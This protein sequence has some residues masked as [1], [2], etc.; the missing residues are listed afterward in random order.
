MRDLHQSLQSQVD[1][2][3][4]LH[5]GY[6]CLIATPIEG[7]HEELGEELMGRNSRA[8]MAK[9]LSLSRLIAARSRS[10]GD[11][12]GTHPDSAQKNAV[13]T[14]REQGVSLRQT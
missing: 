12:L 9:S 14:C 11:F 6:Q 13:E 8:V 3:P 4:Y 10:L 5:H 7:F 1:K 2:G